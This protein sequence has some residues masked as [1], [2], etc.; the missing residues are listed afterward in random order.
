MNVYIHLGFLLR[1]ETQPACQC[2]LGYSASWL[3]SSFSYQSGFSRELEPIETEPTYLQKEIYFKE[4][5]HEIVEIGKSENRTVCWK[6]K[7]DF[8]FR[9]ET[10]FLLWETSIFT[11]ETFKG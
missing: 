5:A 3:L 9:F 7:R 2:F 11:L 6:L 4:L 1:E 8:C 10:E